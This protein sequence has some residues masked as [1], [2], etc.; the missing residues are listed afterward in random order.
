MPVIASGS[1]MVQK[2]TELDAKRSGHGESQEFILFSGRNRTPL[3][4]SFPW[5]TPAVGGRGGDPE[6]AHAR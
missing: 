6:R 4:G 1:V 5:E 3:V 2:P